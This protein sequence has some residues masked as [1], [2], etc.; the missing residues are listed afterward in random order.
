[1]DTWTP[2]PIGHKVRSE[3]YI[4]VRC[5]NHPKAKKNG[6]VFEHRLVMENYL[7]RFLESKEYVHHINGITDDNTID[8]LMIISPSLHAQNHIRSWP[9]EKTQ[10]RIEQLLET[11]KKR[12]LPR[13][14]VPCQC[15][16]HE[17]IMSRNKWGRQM[18][19]KMGHT[20]RGKHWKWHNPKE[21]I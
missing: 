5:P 12:K 20:H 1:M 13:T 16:C 2:L 18:K 17:L 14:L 10:K 4:L 6:Y 7:R 11:I 19:Y 8:N 3:R 9:L 21:P 15:G